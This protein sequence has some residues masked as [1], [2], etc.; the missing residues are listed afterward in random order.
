MDEFFKWLSANNIAGIVVLTAFGLLV[1][2][3]AVIYL[4]AFFEGREISFSPP[5]I[6]ARPEKPKA[7]SA[8]APPQTAAASPGESPEQRYMRE[9]TG[10]IRVYDHL[11]ACR[12]DMQ[13]DFE[14]AADIRLLL[15]I[16]RRELGDSTSSYFWSLAKAKH[17][18]DVRIRILRASEQSPFLSEPRAEFRGTPV[19]RWREDLR[20][21]CKEISFLRDVY[22]V[23]VEERP[24][25]EPYLWRIFIFDDVA[26]VS[27]Y[28]HRRDNDSRAAV[29]KLQD[30][31]NSLFT[32]F[33][34]YFEYLWKKY[35][36]CYSDDPVQLWANWE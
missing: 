14:R 31:P 8:G 28:L 19:E 35:D 15:Q 4:V 25:S 10:I 20:R 21:L 32:V 24:H 22:H 30:G 1:I 2:S 11:G 12:E 9:R 34:K 5:K 3:A 17:Q 7:K 18:P 13:A 27:A 33:C 26:Y 36:P 23:H 16:G 6:G 29:Y